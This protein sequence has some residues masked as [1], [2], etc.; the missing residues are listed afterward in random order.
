V[1]VPATRRSFI[2]AV[3]TLPLTTA[4]PAAS[5]LPPITALT[6]SPDGEQIVAGS[7]AGISVRDAA[8]GEI[9]KSVDV[10]MDNVH[11]FKFS[12]NG[13]TLAVAGG[14]PAEKGV[15]EI[16]HWP[17]LNRKQRLQLHDDVIYS[18]DFSADGSRWVAASGD[19]VC[20]VFKV[21]ADTA[22]T[23]FTQHSR[24]VLAAAFLPDGETI[25]SG[26]RDETLRVWNASSGENLRTLHNHSRDVL[27][28]AAKPAAEG[29]PMIASASADLTV[30]F[31]QPT[32]GRMVRFA[33][34]PSEPLCIA[35]CNDGN[36]VAGCRDAAARLI[37]AQTV[38]I[39]R[40]FPLTNGW[41]SSVA[42]SP[43]NDRRIAFG[44]A[45]GQVMPLLT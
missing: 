38:Q 3:A 11:D 19:E 6:F 15:V 17:T 21:G 14:N 34:I 39:E 26:S 2:A 18:I 20:S 13:T 40:A 4:A 1:S 23:R 33:R 42:V 37:N 43:T 44:G 32:I 9:L 12:P 28:L 24:G 35:W 8:S 45:N 25:V 27:A 10:D 29:L 22:V 41:L 36:L 31:W 5:T 7:Q 16:L 30:R